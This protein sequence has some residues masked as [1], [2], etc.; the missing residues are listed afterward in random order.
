VVTRTFRKVAVLAATTL[1]IPFMNA[2]PAD[3]SVSAGVSSGR[4]ILTGD[5]FADRVALRLHPGEATTLDIDFDDNGVV[6]GSFSRSSFGQIGI[7]M[8]GGIDSVRIDDSAGSFTDTETTQIFGGEGNDTLTGGGGVE[9]LA[10]DGGADTIA[11][12]PEGDLTDGGTGD[13]TFLWSNS[14]GNDSVTDEAGIDRLLVDGSGEAE[15]FAIER[16][17]AP[18]DDRVRI[19]RAAVGRGGANVL[20]LEDIDQLDLDS[21][22]GNDS[23]VASPDVGGLIALDIDAGQRSGLESASGGDDDV[24]TGSDAGDV[25]AGGAGADQL[26]GRGGADA[27]NGGDAGDTLIGGSG[28]DAL[29]G[30]AGADQFGCEGPGEVL[31]AQPDDVVPALC[32]PAAPPEQPA[33]VPAP[34][35][36][37]SASGPAV[38]SL[39]AR[40][41]GFGKPVVR[42]TREG[43][44]VK[45]ANVHS[46]PIAVRV[47]ATERFRSAR[48]TRTL[49]YAMVK[50]TIAVGARGTLKLPAPHTLRAHVAAGLRR[51]G[52]VVRRPIM[53]VTNVATGGQR[54]V[55]PRLVVTASS[56]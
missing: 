48:G 15:Q 19:S 31:D 53:M 6:D 25:I 50:Q 9:L 39:P 10:G 16:F 7:S 52:R 33:P 40:F 43:L 11:G 28:T 56:R 45:V 55:Q 27:L 2:A 24:V 49:R 23:I 4:L 54:T 44:R 20:A 5:G 37:T 13:D 30:G 29:T 3:A 17:P 8:G 21:F 34:A 35:G 41:L 22:G 32:I 36:P 18:L 38:S 1:A 51:A 46:A 26:D 47:V 12:G 42:A 14:D